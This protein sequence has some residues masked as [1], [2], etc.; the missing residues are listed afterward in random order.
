MR[1]VGFHTGFTAVTHNIKL[2]TETIMDKLNRRR[3]VVVFNATLF[4]VFLKIHF[5]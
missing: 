4:W 2:L 5:E 3:G 1:M